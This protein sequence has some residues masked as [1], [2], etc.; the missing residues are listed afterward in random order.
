MASRAAC[1]SQTQARRS[2]TPSRA[3][4][5]VRPACRRRAASR[6]TTPSPHTATERDFLG[7]DEVYKKKYYTPVGARS[8]K[9]LVV[10]DDADVV[11]VI[12]RVLE[13]DGHVVTAAESAEAGLAALKAGSFDAVLLDNGLPGAMGIKAL[14]EFVAATQAPVVMM[15]GHPNE[16]VEKDAL[17]LGAKALVAKPFEPGVVEALLLKLVGEG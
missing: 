4:Q 6:P 8:L 13:R 9:L 17:L 14:T 11:L 3:P 5:R 10:E 1:R 7:T 12:R 16:D 15:T 2:G